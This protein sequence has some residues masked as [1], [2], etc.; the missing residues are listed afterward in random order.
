MTKAPAQVLHSTKHQFLEVVSP[1]FQYAITNKLQLGVIMKS[2]RLCSRATKLW[3][4]KLP[5]GEVVSQISSREFEHP[6]IHIS[7]LSAWCM[8]IDLSI[9]RSLSLSL[10]VYPLAT[11]SQSTHLRLPPSTMKLL[12]HLATASKTSPASIFFFSWALSCWRPLVNPK[13]LGN[14]RLFRTQIAIICPR[15]TWWKIVQ[16]APYSIRF[17][18]HPNFLQFFP[19]IA[20]TRGWEFSSLAPSICHHQESCFELQ[21]VNSPHSCNARETRSKKNAMSETGVIID[22]RCICECKYDIPHIS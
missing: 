15:I 2:H 21:K 13:W 19:H 20:M 10:C 16:E 22:D 17:L 4:S 8:Y 7:I 14:V 3:S 1:Q 12:P 5:A 9:D 6:A 18:D 11:G